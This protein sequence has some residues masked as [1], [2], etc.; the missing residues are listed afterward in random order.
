MRKY[1]SVIASTVALVAGVSAAQA[2]DLMD[3]AKN[4]LEV[5]TFVEA[6]N[7]AGISE[8]LKNKGP[9]TIFAPADS[10]FAKLSTDDKEALFEDKT[11][12]AKV[13]GHHVV[14]GKTTV[15]EVKPGEVQTI[16]GSSLSVKSDNGMVR[17]EGASVI[18]SDLV[19][20]NGVIHIIDSVLLPDK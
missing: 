3:T 17:V 15:A 5:K 13:V 8:E 20:D 2:A 6:A 14:P 9:F 12:L 11:K 16:E 10:A 19:A 18:Q 7:A 4:T 1:L